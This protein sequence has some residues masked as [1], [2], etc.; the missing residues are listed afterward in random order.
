MSLSKKSAKNRAWPLISPVFGLFL[1]FLIA[2]SLPSSLAAQVRTEDVVYLKNGGMVRGQIV[3]LIPDSTL[4]IRILGGTEFVFKWNEIEKIAKEEAAWQEI[5]KQQ[6]MSA[7]RRT[8]PVKY[9]SSGLMISTEFGLF[10]G[11]GGLYSSATIFS[12]AGIANRVISPHFMP[13]IGISFD[14]YVYNGTL[15]PVFFDLR[16][17]FKKEKKL[18]GFYFSQCGYGFAFL[19]NNPT[20]TKYEGGLMAHTGLGLRLYTRTKAAYSM[21]FGYRFQRT[22]RVFEKLFFDPWGA[23][24][25]VIDLTNYYAR[26]SINLG[27]S[28]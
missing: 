3:V 6:K 13:G 24:P 1:F 12:V 11:P 17:D 27:V 4:R 8:G 19:N 25:D 10:A 22:R 18:T 20:I 7:P 26:F 15:V 23:P 16:G 2:Q 5:Q 14:R 9:K 21:S 28:F